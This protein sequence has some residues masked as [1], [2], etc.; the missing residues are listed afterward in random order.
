MENNAAVGNL[1]D[2]V[3]GIHDV[4]LFLDDFADTFGTGGT[5]RQHN[6]DHREH[7]Q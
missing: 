7:H 2:G 1:I 5:L 3:L 4:G 6:E